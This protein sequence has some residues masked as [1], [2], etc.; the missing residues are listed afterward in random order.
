MTAEEFRHWVDHP[1][2]CGKRWE[3]V[4]GVLREMPPWPTSFH[5]VHMQIAKLLGAYV[6]RRGCGSV[7]FRG[8]GLITA[9]APDTVRCPAVMVFLNPAPLEDFPLRFTT[10]V[11]HLVVDL[12]PPRAS[13]TRELQRASDYVVNFGV[14]L[15]W[16]VD[17]EDRCV[18]RY[19]PKQPGSVLD[20]TDELT[21]NGVLPDFSCRVADFFSLPGQQTPAHVPP[22]T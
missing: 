18:I 1:D 4:R 22:T 16:F 9:R 15:V 10:E 2:N 8:D 17:P 7:A 5:T 20:E 12:S 21:G 11:P 6:I 3:L 14:P 13:L 19:V